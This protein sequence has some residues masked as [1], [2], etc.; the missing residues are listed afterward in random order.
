MVEAFN[1]DSINELSFEKKATKE[2]I[3]VEVTSKKYSTFDF[4]S[5][6]EFEESLNSFKNWLNGKKDINYTAEI[7]EVIFRKL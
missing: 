4:Y 7:G 6:E 5:D 2:E 3:L 1:L